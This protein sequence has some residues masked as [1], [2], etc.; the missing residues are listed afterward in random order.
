MLAE[1]YRTSPRAV[2]LLLQASSP[3]PLATQYALHQ[4][5]STTMQALP[6]D[7][8]KRPR[9][10]SLG[11]RSAIITTGLRGLNQRSATR[12]RSLQQLALLTLTITTDFKV[13]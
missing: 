3:S 9:Q 6:D 10:S 12:P 13:L 7:S 8:G 11:R 4:H 1:S 2:L 5:H